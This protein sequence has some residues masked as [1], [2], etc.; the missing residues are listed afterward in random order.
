MDKEKISIIKADG[1][2]AVFD[3]SKLKNS[4]E[5]A[6]AS[7]PIIN[8]IVSKIES[9]LYENITTKE[10]YKKA[11]KLLKTSSRPT[12]ARYKLKNAIMELGP[13]GFPFERFIS[14]ILK[15]EGYKTTVNV[16]MEGKCVRHEI[17]VFAE[18]EKHSYMVECKYHN[19]SGTNSNVRIPLYIQ[20]RFKD[21]EEEWL[22]QAE[23]QSKTFQAWLVTNTRFSGDAMQYGNCVGLK[24]LSWDYPIIGSLKEKIDKSGL[25]PITCLTTL[26][27]AEKQ[28]LLSMD[29]VFS[30]DLCNEPELLKKMKISAYRQKNIL[31]EAKA[32]CKV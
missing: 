25:H 24:L 30:L 26:T 21:V 14:G 20:S 16:F 2:Q 11:F 32:L 22:K 17:D 6:G 3:E 18:K 13:T 9:S 12:A 1:E 31:A 5:R 28:Q 10:I 15:R 8:E 4:L 7:A 23:N 27:K 29:K 19:E